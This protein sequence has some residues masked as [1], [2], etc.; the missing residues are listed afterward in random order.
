MNKKESKKELQKGEF[1][2]ESSPASFEELLGTDAY[3]SCIQFATK[4]LSLRQ[5]KQQ[6]GGGRG[7]RIVR[8]T[9]GMH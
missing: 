3:P 8:K 5:K 4:H 1:G 7:K 6:L 9:D 2:C